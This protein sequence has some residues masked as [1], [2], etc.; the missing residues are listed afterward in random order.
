MFRSSV[1]SGSF[2]RLAV[3]SLQDAFFLRKP[4]KR[5]FKCD[6]KTMILT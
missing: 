5:G 2:L 1:A 4:D 3:A 6:M